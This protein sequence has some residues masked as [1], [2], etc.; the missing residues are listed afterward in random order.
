MNRPMKH[1]TTTGAEYS[2]VEAKIQQV[3][4]AKFGVPFIESP[5]VK[6][7]DNLMLYAEK[8]QLMFS[9][10][11]VYKWGDDQEAADIRFVETSFRQNKS[12][13]LRRFNHLY[14]Q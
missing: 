7:V 14:N 12:L 13:F 1:F 8:R 11:F 6:K 10:N 4:S 3:I 9:K 2:K 5:I